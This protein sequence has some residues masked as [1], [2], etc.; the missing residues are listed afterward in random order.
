MMSVEI[1][2]TSFSLGLYFYINFERRKLSHNSK[3]NRPIT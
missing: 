3:S 1:A 2:L